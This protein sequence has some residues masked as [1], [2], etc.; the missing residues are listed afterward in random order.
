[1]EF[2]PA[3]ALVF[4]PEGMLGAPPDCPEGIEFAAACMVEPRGASVRPTVEV[5]AD[6]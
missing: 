6:I 4:E 1:M 2:K 3:E 5:S